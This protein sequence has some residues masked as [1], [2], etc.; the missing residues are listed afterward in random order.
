MLATAAEICMEPVVRVEEISTIPR[1]YS[2]VCPRR[3]RLREAFARPLLPAC[4]RPPTACRQCRKD[5]GHPWIPLGL[6]PGL[7]EALHLSR[8]SR[9]YAG[10]TQVA[11]CIRQYARAGVK[12]NAQIDLHTDSEK[13]MLAVP[14]SGPSQASLPSPRP[15]RRDYDIAQPSNAPV[16]M[17]SPLNT[18]RVA[19]RSCIRPQPGL[20]E[21]T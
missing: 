10:A 6:S 21:A 7:A 9:E 16:P 4:R 15:N 20:L 12:G 17:R 13:L 11:P 5:L 1:S 14:P 3:C 8:L 2:S 19:A 18:V